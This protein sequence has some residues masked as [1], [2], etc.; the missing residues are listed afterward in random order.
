MNGGLAVGYAH[1]LGLR[2]MDEVYEHPA[3]ADR[4]LIAQAM[5]EDPLPAEGATTA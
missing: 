5:R 3:D 4:A 1:E 2:A